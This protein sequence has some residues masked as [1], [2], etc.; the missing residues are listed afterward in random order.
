MAVL[1][2]S[3]VVLMAIGLPIALTLAGS[4]FLFVLD[5]GTMPW[6]AVMHRMVSGIDSFPL[7]AIPFFVMAGSLMNSAGITERLDTFGVAIVGWL[8][9]GLGQVN[10]VGSVIFAG[11]S[12]TAVAD[13]AGL[14]MIEIKAM[15]EHGYSPEFA[16]GVSAASSLL[17]PILPPSLPLV[18]YGV[19]ANASIGQLF[20]AGIIPGLILA[21]SLMV[22]VSAY[23]RIYNLPRDA[24][25]SPLNMLRAF[26][27]AFLPLMLPVLLIGGM[28][29]GAFTPTEGAVAA[30]AY[31]LFLGVVVYRSLSLK[32]FV[33]VS[34][35]TVEVSA[36]ILL[37][38]AGSE[39][40]GWLI[41]TTRI[42][43]QI[44]DMVYAVSQQRWVILL[45][46][47][48]VLLL[49][50]LAL[51]PVPLILILTPVLMPL[52]ER[53]GVDPVHFGMIM[54][55][56]LMIGLLTPPVGIVTMILGR[57]AGISFQQASKAVLPFMV[58][59]LVTLGLVTYW[60]EMVLY[61]P[62]LWYR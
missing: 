56:N 44:A 31:A 18:I 4:S 60:P 52:I 5:Q 59:L 21:A 26:R 6:V 9:G 29:V 13:A 51:E 11:M 3:F 54:V 14:G 1:T 62:K 42:S 32:A 27:R 16:V 12:G 22:M 23:A 25:F 50:G 39:I 15:K 34:I 53:I 17:G 37:I 38:L 48:V 24:A 57:I 41:T 20:A 58:P 7:L 8:R 35:E 47:N 43:D 10:I 46:L 49:L 30:C 55:I 61:L 36:V 45:L 33:K 2:L 40:F 19:T 28:R